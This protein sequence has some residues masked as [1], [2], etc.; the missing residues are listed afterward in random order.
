MSFAPR[1]VRVADLLATAEKE[2]GD[3]TMVAGAGA[4][5]WID[6]LPPAPAAL[7]THLAGKCLK[8]ADLAKA[9]DTSE[10]TIREGVAA[11]RKISGNPSVISNRSGFGYFRPDDQPDWHA[12][13]PKRHR[14]IGRP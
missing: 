5:G 6:R 7:W 2:R 9:L 12:V 1:F 11:I 4:N 10:Q 13:I 8:A 3:G 14:R